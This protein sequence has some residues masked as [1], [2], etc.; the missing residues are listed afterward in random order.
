MTSF[1]VSARKTFSEPH[2]Q[3]RARGARCKP[4]SLLRLTNV[5]RVAALPD[6]PAA[7]HAPLQRIA[8]RLLVTATRFGKASVRTPFSKRASAPSSA[9]SVGNSKLRA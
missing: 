3:H 6:T 8:S 7:V 5:N 9:T 2:F 4:T 1:P